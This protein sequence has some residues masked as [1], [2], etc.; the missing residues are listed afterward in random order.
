MGEA[1]RRL[2]PDAKFNWPELPVSKMIGLRNIV[3]HEYDSV[4]LHVVWNLTRDRIPEI[5]A[6]LSKQLE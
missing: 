6:Y 1:A 3:V 2:S 5:I 4:D